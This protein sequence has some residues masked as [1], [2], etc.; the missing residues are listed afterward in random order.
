MKPVR[1]RRV[2]QKHVSAFGMVFKERH[3]DLIVGA[4][5]RFTNAR[6]VVT[7]VR[8]DEKTGEAHVTFGADVTTRAQR[9]GRPLQRTVMS[10]AE[11]DRAIAARKEKP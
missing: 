4:V 5:V 10:N 11:Y 3:P 1:I 8:I 6:Y 7:A 9:K 2:V